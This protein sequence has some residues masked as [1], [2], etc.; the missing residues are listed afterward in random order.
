MLSY[1]MLNPSGPS[2]D[3]LRFPQRQS[4][5]LKEHD[6]V[7]GTYFIT[8][9]VGGRRPLLSTVE[10]GEVLPTCVGHIVAE[11]WLRTHE[12]RPDVFTD[13]FVVM[14]DH[15]H[16][17]VGLG[18]LVTRE[19]GLPAGSRAP[20]EMVGDPGS[21]A[22]AVRPYTLGRIVAGVKSSCT[23]QYRAVTRQAAGSLW[24]RG[25]HEHVIRGT[26]ELERIRRYIANNPRAGC[27]DRPGA[28]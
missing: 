28:P 1:G 23:R 7:G 4:V 14:P 15:F 19:I 16:G 13:A 18:P 3:P 21:R 5:R 27:S 17:I 8:I 24:Q 25:Y 9:C 11:E 6:Y 22:H 10:A 20:A 12:M 2:L 26:A